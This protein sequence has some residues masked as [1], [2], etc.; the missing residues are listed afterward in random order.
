MATTQ[1]SCLHWLQLE[2]IGETFENNNNHTDA[3]LQLATSEFEREGPLRVEEVC[4]HGSWHP[5]A[6]KEVLAG[7]HRPWS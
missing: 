7:Y 6:D 2:E 4:E 3:A 5:R 1:N